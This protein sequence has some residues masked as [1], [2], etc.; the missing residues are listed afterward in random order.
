MIEGEPEE[1]NLPVCTGGPYTRLAM[2]I[3]TLQ[4]LVEQHGMG[5]LLHRAILIIDDEPENLDVLEA[6]LQDEGL[7]V[8]RATDG[9]SGLASALAEP[10]DLVISDQR[11]PG[12]TGVDLLSRLATDRPDV[13]G[14]V[15]SAYTDAPVILQAINEAKVFRFL[16]KPF[17]IGDLVRTVREAQ[18][19]VFYRRAVTGLLERL[20]VRNE[21][22]TRTL[23]E[24]REAQQRMLHME[25]LSSMGRLATGVVHD[26]R[27][28]L[29]GLTFL[30]ADLESMGASEEMKES[31]RVGLSG[32]H[33][34]MGT[35]ESMHQFSRDGRLGTA[36]ST[37]DVGDLVRDA[38]VVMRGDV[39][40]RRR[41]VQTFVE[42]GL[43]PIQGDR[44]K[45]IQVLVNLLRNA[46][47]ATIQ[48]QAITVS[49]GILQGGQIRLAVE[50][51]GP[52]LPEGAA[53]RLFEPFV[54]TK[55]EGGLGMGL[56][57]A[58]LI[59][60]AHNGEIGA[61]NRPS[62][63]ARFEVRLWPDPAGAGSRPNAPVS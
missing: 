58:R 16:T 4:R 53:D 17:D 24:L 37:V 29:M 40:F 31:V 36:I 43:P 21:D 27:N 63:G 7:R 30:E 62:G 9:P 56:Y 8:V 38:L 5:D 2:G 26:L 28:A 39:E 19:M 10:L 22:L 49:A 12:L 13:V 25:R 47:Q 34:L 18:E 60:E 61:V 14:I 33:A 3:E 55:G 15:L 23:Q 35:L 50:D 20:A 57:M 32:L 45:L 54:S 46:V 48:G 6:V 44:G 1:E 59:V 51:E 41:R 11:M 52:G 42:D